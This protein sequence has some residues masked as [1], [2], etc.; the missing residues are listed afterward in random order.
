MDLPSDSVPPS[1]TPGTSGSGR[2]FLGRSITRRDAK[3]ATKDEHEGQKGPLGLTT[4]YEPDNQAIVDLV[5]V[6]GLNGGS[7]T[8]TVD[9]LET[10]LSR[11]C[12]IFFLGTPHKGAGIAQLLSRVLAF[13]P[14][15]RPFV[16]DLSPQSAM[17]QSINEAF[18]RYSQNLQLLSFYETLP[19]YYGIGKGLIVEKHCA[20]MNYPNERRTYLDANHRDVA[21]FSARSEP[22]YVLVRNALA[23]TIENQRSSLDSSWREV[24]RDDLLALSR[25]LGVSSAP[26]DD[27]MAHDFQKHPGS[28]EWFTQGK[29]FQQWGDGMTSKVLWLRGRPGAG[30]SV[31]SSHVISHLCARSLD[32]SY[33]FFAEGDKSKAG[34]NPFLR[35]MAWQMAVLHPEA[36]SEI[37]YLSNNWQDTPIDRVD[38]SPV[39]RD[40]F[41]TALLKVRLK[42][43]QY[44]V[45]DAL[46]ECRNGSEL[47]KFLGKLQEKWPL[48]VLITSRPGLEAYVTHSTLSLDV[49]SET[50]TEE[51]KSDIASFLT[52]NLQNLPGPT[53][54]AQQTMAHRIL[55]NSNGCFLWVNL[56]LKELRQDHTSAEISQVLDSNPSDM[57]AFYSR[58]LDGMSHAKFG[59][60]LAKA[61]LTWTTCAFR[62]LSTEEIHYA[63]EKDI[64]DSVDDI[65]KSVSSCCGNLV[66]VD[67]ARKAHLVHLTAREFLTREGLESEYMIDG[68]T[69]HKRLAL[70][71]SGDNEI[72]IELAKFLSS[73][74]VLNWI[75]R[76]SRSSDLQRLYQAG[77]NCASLVLSPFVQAYGYCIVEG[78]H[79]VSTVKWM[80]V[81]LITPRNV[82]IYDNATLLE[83][84]TFEHGEPVWSIAFGSTGKLLATGGAKVVRIWDL[85]AS[86]QLLSFKVTAVC[87]ALAFM[88]EDDVLV[89]VTKNNLITYWD[90]VHDG[91][92]DDPID[93]TRDLREGDDLQLHLK[94]P[95]IAAISV[96]QDLLAVIYRGEDI[97]LWS[98]NEGP[99]T[100]AIT[101]LHFDE[102]SG[103][104]TCSD[105]AGTVT[106]R[107]IVRKPNMDWDSHD[108]VIYL[109]N[110]FVVVN[111]VASGKHSRLLMSTSQQD[112]LL[113]LSPENTGE[114]I[115]RIDGNTK[116]RWAVS[117]LNDDVLVR[118][119]ATTA[120]SFSWKTLERVRSVDLP[121]AQNNIDSVI[122][123]QHPQYLVT[124][125]REQPH[126]RGSPTT[127]HLWDFRDFMFQPQLT[128]TSQSE[129]VTV[130]PAL[131]FGVLDLKVESIIGVAKERIIFLTPDNWVCSAE[132]GLPKVDLN[133]AT[134]SSRT[135]DGVVRHFFIPDEWSS[136]VH[137][138]LI[139][140]RSSGEIIFIKRTELVVI[141]RG[142]EVT[143]RGSFNTHRTS[144]SQI[145]PRRAADKRHINV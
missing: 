118:F 21:R 104:L 67:K 27:L 41:S 92:L 42:K 101:L 129:L 88:E 56:V 117:P 100:S 14:G 43:P 46:D 105:E 124:A 109:R 134:G 28:C 96:E 133:P 115:A 19:M 45:I 40:V 91:P 107:K 50:I 76:L 141:R 58:I 55:C 1:T 9:G 128:N 31:L 49:V 135:T 80:F 64:K 57:D 144:S 30:K 25:F 4:L 11:V 70:V 116:P 39:W 16:N 69:G 5:F 36:F 138:V 52:T 83:R 75:E 122:T 132:I 73:H 68:A 114:C 111:A 86:E 35:S 20:V 126:E 6:H 99:G 15:S 143:E 8:L 84:D 125:R 63:V 130:Q 37:C 112:I 44:W 93:W 7:V 82:L 131:D 121:S 79:S 81:K 13:A 61:I 127:Y 65:E 2:S 102:E 95:T 24:K 66:Y 78:P 77:Q 87:K 140:V 62:P 34:I 137:R 26:E 59:K 48:C 120:S 139:D 85:D 51:N 123:L 29:T 10:D 3:S 33:Y 145:L 103:L 119:E 108:P 90:I 113:S 71:R 22:S 47:F 72:F 60:D 142:L 74:D 89:A 53:I 38:H 94:R 23:M 54:G 97:V 12:A 106:C 98:L 110:G 32:C 136:L 17:L 18:P